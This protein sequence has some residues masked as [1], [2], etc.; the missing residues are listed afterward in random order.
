MEAV[1]GEKSAYPVVPVAHNAGEYWA[2]R[3]L[4]KKPGTIQV[5]IGPPID[6]KGLNAREINELAK[7]W[8]AGQ[9]EQIT[10]L[11]SDQA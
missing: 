3:S 1:V 4:I 8:I 2:R 11:K 9:M 6:T 5:R 10:T 7:K